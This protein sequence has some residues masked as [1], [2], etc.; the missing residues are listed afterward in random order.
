[1]SIKERYIHP[2]SKRKNRGKNFKIEGEKHFFV[3][4]C[5]VKNTIFC[6]SIIIFEPD[7]ILY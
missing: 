4:A 1:M 5:G 3:A 7:S 6:I 2:L